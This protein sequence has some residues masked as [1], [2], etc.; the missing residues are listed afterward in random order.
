MTRGETMARS[1]MMS[2]NL[3]LLDESQNQAFNTE[4][5]S[6]KELEC[7]ILRI[8]GYFGNQAFSIL[9]LGGGNGRFLDCPSS[10]LM[11]QLA[12]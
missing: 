1:E 10:E 9:D 2:L 5:H 6:R 11:G 12:D 8:A 4:F 3:V 7:K